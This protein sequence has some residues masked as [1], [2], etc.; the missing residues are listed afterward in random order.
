M[1]GLFSN[2]FTQ[3]P[4]FGYNKSNRF[5][6]EIGTPV[7]EQ[8]YN[9]RWYDKDMDMSR[10]IAAM[11]LFPYEIQTILCEGTTQ[12]A[13]IEFHVK[14]QENHFKSL[15]LDKLERLWSSTLKRR[16][17]DRNPMMFRAV[18]YMSIM[19]EETRRL[20]LIKANELLDFTIEHYDICSAADTEPTMDEV[21]KMTY[22]Y[23]TEGSTQAKQFVR[24]FRKIF[25]QLP[26]KNQG[27]QYNF[28]DQIYIDDTLKLRLKAEETE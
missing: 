12:I 3:S 23:V 2:G 4:P 5:F 17:Y 6:L 8:L 28:T 21:A 26:S 20:L 10:F 25:M 16:L 1:T 18:N 19:S 9:R 14:E 11:C 22:I 15:G 13:E 7:A 27:P 24:E